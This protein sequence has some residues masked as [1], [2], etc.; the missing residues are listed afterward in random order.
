MMAA[1]AGDPA[2]IRI[3]IEHGA[4]VNAAESTH[5]QTALMFAA[6]LNR[7]DAVALLMKNGADASLSTKVVKPE[8][9]RPDPDLVPM[10]DPTDETTPLHG[11]GRGG[12]DAETRRPRRGRCAKW[13]RSLPAA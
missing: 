2:A 8:R 9:F 1:S 6:A 11:N 4:E 10:T 5:G 7:S 12:A 13:A 3:M